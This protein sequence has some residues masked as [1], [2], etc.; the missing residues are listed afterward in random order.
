MFSKFVLS[1]FFTI[2]FINNG[3]AQDGGGPPKKDQSYS[4]GKS[5]RKKWK[6]ERAAKRAEERRIQ[7]HHDHTQTKAVRKR[8]KRSKVIAQRNNDNKRAPFFERL[9]NKQGTRKA[10]RQPKERKSKIKGN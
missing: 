1:I 2:I 4:G 3:L 8:M 10:N 9:F 6:E 5:S 7:R